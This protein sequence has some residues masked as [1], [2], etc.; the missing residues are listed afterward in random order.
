MRLVCL[1]ISCLL[2]GLLPISLSAQRISYSEPERED[3]RR[4]NFEIIGKMDG[5]YLIFKGNRTDNSIS[6][7]DNDMKMINRVPLEFL[8]DR[9]INIDF[10]AYPEVAYM[11]Y[12]YQRKNV[13]HCSMVRIDSK[14]KPIGEPV[15]L[16][17]TQIGWAAN[18]KIYTTLVS[19]DKQKIMVFKI[20]SKNQ[21]NFLFTTLLF[22][23][24][25]KLIV[26]KQRLWL[27]MEERN[28]Y[29]TDFLLDNEGDL[30]FGKL[31]RTNSNNYISK[32]SLVS[33]PSGSDSF[34][35][36]ELSTGDKMLDEVK[37]KVDNTNRRYL[38]TAFYYKQRRGN[39]EGLYAATWDKGS[40]ALHKESFIVFNDEL[41]SLAKSSDAN[42][43]MA[44]NDY[45]I[46]NIITKK[47]GGFLLISESQY[48]T[49]RGGAFNRWDYM[50]WNNPWLSPVDYYYYSPL[51]SPW[52]SPWNRWN[53]NQATRYHAENIMILSFDK[54]GKVAWSNVIP[55]SQY[56]DETDNLISHQIMNT[57][58]E[59][60]FLF[61]QYERKNLML[62]DQSIG[63]DGK[64][65]R[66]PTLKNLDKGYEFMPRH[67]KQVSAWEMIVPCTYRNYLCFAKVEF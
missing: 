35:V 32:V 43:R 27:P 19:D 41:R 53:T 21:K 9:W 50:R 39:I 1:V 5:N 8:P 13:V 62:S 17:T 67:G 2:L 66:Y 56:D 4:T 12:Q 11:I 15:D 37:I 7:Y 59:L 33:K 57:G 23:N 30:V 49:S 14:G 34:L 6:I 60:H 10:I 24:N 44:F 25:M 45:F 36:R 31:E 61:N 28:D 65:T 55:K 64:I 29:F 58:G 38:F 16:D 46:N 40:R 26:D 42:Q 18:N 54:D 48:T 51:Y 63:P 22:D 52:Y 20:N 47:D 3:S